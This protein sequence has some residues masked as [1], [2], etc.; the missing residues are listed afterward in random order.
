MNPEYTERNRA[1]PRNKM[2]D[3]AKIQGLINSPN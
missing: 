1:G 3:S 2:I